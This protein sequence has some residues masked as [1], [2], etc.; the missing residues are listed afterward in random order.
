MIESSL[1]ARRTFVKKES[2]IAGTVR[3]ALWPL[4]QG[5]TSRTGGADLKRGGL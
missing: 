5:K 3:S 1:D 4:L 2:T